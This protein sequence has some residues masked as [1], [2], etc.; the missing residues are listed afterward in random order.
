MDWAPSIIFCATTREHFWRATWTIQLTYTASATQWPVTIWTTFP[1]DFA[2]PPGPGG[3]YRNMNTTF[4]R[5][6]EQAPVYELPS[7]HTLATTVQKNISNMNVQSSPGFDPFSFSFIKHAEKTIQDDHGKRHWKRSAFP[8]HW[9]VPSVPVRRCHPSSLEQSQNYADLHKKGPTTSPK[10]YR[11]LAING[12]IYRLFANVV[13]DLLTDWAL[14]EHQ[15]PDS[16]FGFCPTRNT[17][18]YSS[19][20]SHDC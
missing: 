19:P 8:S 13:R 11:L 3:R 20:H 14:A 10:N 15:I 2:V 18:L 1:S 4:Q 12:C 17:P 16:Q 9:L 6:N 7:I 5:S